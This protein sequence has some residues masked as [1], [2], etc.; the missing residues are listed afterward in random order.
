MSRAEFERWMTEDYKC[1]IGS[2][3]PYPAGI[4]RDMWRCWQAASFPL[5]ARVAELE[6]IVKQQSESIGID[7]ALRDA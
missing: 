3:D 6:A 5:A 2:S 1:V 7:R 4:E